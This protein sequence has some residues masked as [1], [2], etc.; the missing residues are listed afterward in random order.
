MQECHKLNNEMWYYVQQAY[1]KRFIA[2]I[3]LWFMINKV[4]K[5]KFLN[6][7]AKDS[8]ETSYRDAPAHI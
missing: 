7:G 2:A 3:V 4:F 8:H 6:H 1:W 5:K